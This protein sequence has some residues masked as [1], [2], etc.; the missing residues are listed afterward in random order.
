MKT[1][2]YLAL[3]LVLIVAAGCGQGK[4][5]EI[6]EI[7][8]W[9]LNSLDGL[10]VK[11]G[12]EIDNKF[13]KDGKGSLKITTPGPT[14]VNLFATGPIPLDKA[15]LIYQAMIRT[16]DVAG[17]VYL[18]MWCGFKGKGEFFSRA[19]QAP[20]KGT[21]DWT[22]QQTPFMLQD[23]QKPDYVRLNL[24]ITGPGVVWVDDV[25]LLAAPL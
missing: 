11:H 22:M 3:A 7:K 16:E 17:D 24:V 4:K 1:G 13:S 9:P 6:R 23:D 8:A 14:T 15:R 12:V 25:K 10:L 5:N 19:L 18:E 21:T 20:Q 2:R